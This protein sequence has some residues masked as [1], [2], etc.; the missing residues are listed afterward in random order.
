MEG[1]EEKHEKTSV[2][3]AYLLAKIFHS[4]HAQIRSANHLTKMFGNAASVV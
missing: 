4:S 2:R 1:T 3:T